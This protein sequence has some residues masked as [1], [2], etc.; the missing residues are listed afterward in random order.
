MRLVKEY[1]LRDSQ[2]AFAILVQRHINLVYSAAV[3]HVGDPHKAQDVTQAVFVILARKAGGLPERTVLAGWLYQAAR[4]TAASHLRGERRRQQREQES[5]MQSTLNEGEP[6]ASWTE[7]SPML[8]DAMGR[9]GQNDREAIL[10]RYFEGKSVTEMA[11]A[12]RM[13]EAAVKKRMARA[14]ERLRKFFVKR[15]IAIS[16]TTLAGAISAHSVQAAPAGLAATVSTAA[17][18]KGAA[19][20]SSTL[21]MV[22][23]GLKL[24]AW[25]KFKS[26]AVTGLMVLLAVGTTTVAVEKLSASASSSV[27]DVFI[28]H[29]DP[30]YLNRAPRTVIVRPSKYADG[31]DWVL[32]WQNGRIMRRNGD[33]ASLLTAAYGWS[34]ER[35]V[36]PADL[37][38]GRFDMLVTV[39]DR[40]EKALQE[41]LRRQFGIR[42]YPESRVEDVLVLKAIQG[43]TRTG[44][45]PDT[46]AN[47]PFTINTG[48][49]IMLLKKYK[50]G[51]L[52]S[53]LGAQCFFKPVID[54]TGI[55]GAFDV[56]I[57]W[58][59][60]TELSQRYGTGNPPELLEKIKAALRDQLGLEVVPDRRAVTMLVVEQGSAPLERKFPSAPPLAKDSWAF[61]GYATP[62]DTFQSSLWA[63]NKGDLKAFLA[64]LTPD[65]K[66]HFME[67]AGK[68]GNESRMVAQNQ[69][70]AAGVQAF[71]V[72]SSEEV[73]DEVVILHVKSTHFGNGQATLRKVDGEW[74]MASGIH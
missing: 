6:E 62:Q 8:D 24:M 53:A 52:A 15:G 1:A 46:N 30:A 7:L 54:E 50:M 20:G 31:G 61:K 58:G 14:L 49:G 39:A 64:S 55:K 56:K 13:K 9:L 70:D 17:A 32:G 29:N 11:G 71:Q 35:M 18:A 67:T 21:A 16:G 28:H 34:P 57:W 22:K 38:T 3:R 69:R 48:P 59:G 36:L 47:S 43:G 25:T 41:E 63:M 4:F 10:L 42:T 19:L 51:D 66:Q 23:G 68:S 74:K 2:E 33:F 73:S 27:E 65:E 26:A 40:P 5:Y 60:T 44:L 12:L 45:Q 72:I 37:P